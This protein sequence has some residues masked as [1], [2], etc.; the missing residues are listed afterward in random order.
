MDDIQ[1]AFAS[2]EQHIAKPVIPWIKAEDHPLQYPKRGD[3]LMGAPVFCEDS[4]IKGVPSSK[5]HPCVV[6]KVVERKDLPGKPVMAIVL[7]MTHAERGERKPSFIPVQDKQTSRIKAHDGKQSYVATD[8]PN[9]IV[10]N[11]DNNGVRKQS[12]TPPWASPYTYGRV[13]DDYLLEACDEMTKA[14]VERTRYS[15][16]MLGKSPTPEKEKRREP[17]MQPQ[18]EDYVKI[19][20]AASRKIAQKSSQAMQS[21]KSCLEK[22]GLEQTSP[23]PHMAR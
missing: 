18:W 22:A 2:P 13:K 5:E 1:T 23:H 17:G 21:M 8:S 20:E 7:P 4:R 16:P 6:L 14:F 9:V 12:M 3:I 19:V 11:W 15:P 10:L